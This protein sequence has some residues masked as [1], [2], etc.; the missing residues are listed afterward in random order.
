MADIVKENDLFKSIFESAVEGI[1]VVDPNGILLSVNPAAE[2]IFDYEPGELIN[3]KLEILIPEK[4]IESHLSQRD[5]YTKNPIPR[6]KEGNLGLLGLKKNG[7]KFPVRVSL[8]P[9]I[10]EGKSITIMFVSDAS[11]LKSLSKN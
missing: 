9:T 1:L 2:F 6:P 8:S 7:S 5:N 3:Q 11:E 10:I 4:L